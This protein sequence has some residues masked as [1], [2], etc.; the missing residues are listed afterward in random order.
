MSSIRKELYSYNVD[1]LIRLI[2]NRQIGCCGVYN[3]TDYNS[4]DI[5]WDN[6]T[7]NGVPLSCCKLN[8]TTDLIK[9]MSEIK[10]VDQCLSPNLN[11]IYINDAVSFVTISKEKFQRNHRRDFDIFFEPQVLLQNDRFG[12]FYP[13]SGSMW[14]NS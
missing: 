13:H 3:W 12:I 5:D 10:D 7:T 4:T 14:G 2:I 11:P 1:L 8:K 9:Q 6:K